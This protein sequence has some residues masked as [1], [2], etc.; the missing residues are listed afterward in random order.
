MYLTVSQVVNTRVREGGDINQNTPHSF[1]ILQQSHPNMDIVKPYICFETVLHH[2]QHI[3]REF[4][5]HNV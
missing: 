1:Q 5:E 2:L 4:N 3:M